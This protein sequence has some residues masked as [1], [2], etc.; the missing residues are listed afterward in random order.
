MRAIARLEQA[1]FNKLIDMKLT[2]KTLLSLVMP[3]E[4][5]WI[6]DYGFACLN[7]YTHVPALRNCTVNRR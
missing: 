3:I 1:Q 6:E 7:I 5:S 2:A 4:T